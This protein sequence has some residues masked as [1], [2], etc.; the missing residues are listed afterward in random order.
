[1]FSYCLPKEEET[2]EQYEEKAAKIR[3]FQENPL[4]F[5]EREK[6]TLPFSLED[7]VAEPDWDWVRAFLRDKF[8]ISPSFLS[9]FYSNRGLFFWQGAQTWIFE[10][11][12]FFLLQIRKNFKKGNLLFYSKEEVLSHEAV[13]AFRFDRKES[14]FDEIFAYLTSPRLFRRIFGPLFQKNREVFFL[15][16]F[17]FSPFLFLGFSPFLGLCSFLGFLLLFGFSL[18]RLAYYHNLFKKAYK[19]LEKFA[20]KK[21]IFP[22]LVRLEGKEIKEIAKMASSSLREF[23]EEKKKDSLRWEMIEKTYFSQ[24]R[25]KRFE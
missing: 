23:F 1:M 22:I 7:K 11:E 21:D 13:H 12:G 19:A 24:N 2:L 5:L 8:D 10:K 4:P 9:A 14:F 25:E 20:E 18:I 6:I 16:L 3:A 17:A 15:F